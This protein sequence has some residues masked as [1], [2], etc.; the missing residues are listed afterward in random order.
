MQNNVCRPSKI[1]FFDQNLDFVLGLET[2]MGTVSR[3]EFALF[4]IVQ[5]KL[6]DCEILLKKNETLK[7]WIKF[8][9]KFGKMIEIELVFIVLTKILNFIDFWSKL[10]LLQT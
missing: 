9:T 10:F 1:S 7:I 2:E 3:M 5:A 4:M 6:V 8:S